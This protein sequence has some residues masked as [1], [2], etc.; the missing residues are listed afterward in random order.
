MYSQYNNDM[1]KNKM[2]KKIANGKSYIEIGVRPRV[3]KVLEKIGL[4]DLKN[5]E[6][7]K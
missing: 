1:V 2:Y 4:V 3:L 5:W 6:N 7:K